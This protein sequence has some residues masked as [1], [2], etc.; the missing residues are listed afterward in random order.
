MRII[1]KD[2]TKEAFNVQ[3]VVNAVNKSAFRV[4]VKFTDEEKD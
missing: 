4:L 3:K 1:K 2:N